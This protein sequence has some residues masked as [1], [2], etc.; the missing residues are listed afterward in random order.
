MQLQSV[1]WESKA[2]SSNVGPFFGCKGKGW[3][4]KK[5]KRGPEVFGMARIIIS[6][7]EAFVA[8]Q[9]QLFRLARTAS[10]LLRPSSEY[11]FYN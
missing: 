2:A 4:W 11:K 9:L 7:A 10:S 3:L 1:Q 8:S 5:L 6:S